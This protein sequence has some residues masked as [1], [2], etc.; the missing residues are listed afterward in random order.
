MG[1]YVVIRIGEIYANENLLWL[2]CL[3]NIVD[4]RYSQVVPVVHATLYM[5]HL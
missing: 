2:L 5:N 4:I 1:N 3:V